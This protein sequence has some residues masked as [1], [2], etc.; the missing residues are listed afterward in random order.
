MRH[1][2]N[3]CKDARHMIIRRVTGALQ[4]TLQLGE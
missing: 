4:S 1:P 2:R 3:E